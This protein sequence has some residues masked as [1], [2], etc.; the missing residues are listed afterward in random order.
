MNNV[1]MFVA[2]LAGLV[3]MAILASTIFAAIGFVLSLIWTYAVLAVWPTLPV[4][5]WWQ[6]SLLAWGVAIIRGLI[7]GTK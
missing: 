1:T 5:I 2:A 3:A 6:F 7:V 4:I